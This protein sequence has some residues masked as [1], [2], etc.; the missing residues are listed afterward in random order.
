M[1]TNYAV[2]VGVILKENLD[3]LNMSQKELCKKID[4]HPT[5][6][7]EIIKGKRK[8][9]AKIATK[10]VDVFGLSAKYWM[11]IQ[12]EYELASTKENVKL[13]T[14]DTLFSAGYTALEIA[15]RFISYEHAEMEKNAYYEGSLS[16]L[17]LQKLLYFA[18]KKALEKNIILFKD[19]IYNWTYGPVVKS[20]FN[21]YKSSRQVI[22]EIVE[23]KPLQSDI[24]KLLK[25]IFDKYKKFTA[26]YMVEQSHKEKAW[27]LTKQNEEIT[28]ELIRQNL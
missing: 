9:N 2:H 19:R 28:L 1:E 20:V 13:V 15:N 6:I 10:L 5:V 22:S 24:E 12:S 18:Q 3:A 4:E 11:N 8:M 17:K 23:D 14:D 16:P 25:S 21:I 7:N 26:A 27:L